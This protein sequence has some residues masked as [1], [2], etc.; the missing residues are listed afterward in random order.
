[1][2]IKDLV[3]YKIREARLKRGLTQKQAARIIGVSQQ[4]WANYESGRI[5]IRTNDLDVIAKALKEPVDYFI[6]DSSA[7]TSLP[8][9][10]KDLTRQLSRREQEEIRDIIRLKLDR[11]YRPLHDFYGELSLDDT[12]S[13]T[14]R[15]SGRARAR[16]RRSKQ[17][18]SKGL[19]S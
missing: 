16:V 8:E 19:G 13:P 4:T 14:G 1:M 5:G 6:I 7:D 11:D 3:R 12:M 17:N 10:V 15:A 2:L 18:N 9:Q